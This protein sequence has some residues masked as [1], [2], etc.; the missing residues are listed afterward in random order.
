MKHTFLK[1]YFYY[2]VSLF[3]F[4]FLFSALLLREINIGDY[5]EKNDEIILTITQNWPSKTAFQVEDKITKP[6]EMILKSVTGYSELKSVSDFGNVKLFL[7]K[8]PTIEKQELLRL[9]RNVYLLNQNQF[10]NEVHFPRFVYENQNDAFVILLKRKSEIKLTSLEELKQKI[11]KSNYADKL[12]YQPKFES[13]IQLEMRQDFLLEVS[14]PSLS[15]IYHSIRSYFDVISFDINEEKFYFRDYPEKYLEWEKV[16]LPFRKIGFVPLKRMADV[17]LKKVH[18]NRN[19]RVNGESFESI[20]IQTNTVF[21]QLL[22]QMYLKN[23]LEEHDDWEIVFTSHEDLVCHIK[24]FLFFYLLIDFFILIYIGAIRKFWLEATCMVLCFLL[25]VIVL[26][27]FLSLAQFPIGNSGIALLFFLKICSPFIPCERCLIVKKQIYS[28]ILFLCICLYYHWIPLSIMVILFIFING[29]LVYPLFYKLPFILINQTNRKINLNQNLKLPLIH[30]ILF[31]ESKSNSRYSV[32]LSGI[33][34]MISMIISFKDVLAPFP[35]FTNFGS[36]KLARLEFPTYASESE[37]NRI[38][39]QVEET[40][41]DHKLTNLLVVTQKNF[42]SD[43]YIKLSEFTNINQ[44]NSLPTEIGYFHFVNGKNEKQMNVLRFTNQNSEKMESSMKK[45]LPWLKSQKEI[46]EVVLGF[47]PSSEGIEFHTNPTSRVQMGLD[48]DPTI[49]ESSFILNPSVVGKMYLN[50]ALIDVKLK[51]KQIFSKEEYSKQPV[52]DGNGNFIFGSA[53]RESNVIQNFARIYHKETEPS[54]EVFVKGNDVDWEKIEN[55]LKFILKDDTTLFVERSIT[56]TGDLQ[57]RLLFLVLFISILVYRQ[58]HTKE[59]ISF[60]I[61]ILMVWKLQ[62]VMFARD[63]LQFT[64]VIFSFL[65]LRLKFPKGFIR[66]L[67]TNV[68]FLGFLTLTYIYP[69][70]GGVYL[71]ESMFLVFLFGF[72]YLKLND[73]FLKIKTS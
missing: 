15:E 41:L 62:S 32:I 33:L 27:F 47:Q 10:P 49:K 73:R 66:I 71:F 60:L 50:E 45:I 1:K 48:I 56:N 26:F 23:L 30:R 3:G 18:I 69:W 36:I 39:K 72:I 22:L 5:H 54:M 55:G 65:F 16:I 20:L 42:R 13:E 67:Y 28:L 21:K 51:V 8:N 53:I 14:R 64:I 2:I 70:N 12:V 52:S 19:T 61:T 46:E 38:T 57:F 68:F 58:K 11:I 6:W 35:I 29:V 25:H 43:F 63:Y 59:F 9:I 37:M 34:M 17:S 44:F 31:A 4:V 40:I 24:E 7:K